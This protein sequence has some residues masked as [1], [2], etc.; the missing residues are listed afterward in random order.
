MNIL[1]KITE[2]KYEEVAARKRKVEVSALCDME[3][4]DQQTLSLR[5][6]LN[7]DSK[8]SIIAE[9]KRSSPTADEFRKNAVAEDVA[10]EYEAHG[11]SAISVLTDERFFSGSL[12]DMCR[13][14]HTVDLP[15]LRKDFI[16]DEYQLCEAKAHGGDAVLL[17]A[18]VLE[19]S[20]ML[21]LYIAARELGLE[22]LVELYSECELDMV[23]LDQM[24]LLGINN[25]D[26]RTFE[27]DLNRTITVARQIPKDVTIV[28]ESGIHTADDLRRL[29]AA[30]V[31]AALIGECFMKAEHPGKAL[32][33]LLDCIHS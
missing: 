23:D 26:L 4:F 15:I 6:A 31:R 32:Q 30:G 19:T 12:D 5:D 13:V 29:Q 21:N 22:A 25:R 7:R 17:I 3:F 8:F 28:S 9:F 18:A 1:E 14:R 24:K 20:Q 27:V 2:H 11:A 16:I 33:E 10:R